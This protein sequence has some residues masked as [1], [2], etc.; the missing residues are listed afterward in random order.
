MSFGVL[1][2]GVV[3]SFEFFCRRALTFFKR[4]LVFMLK[5]VQ[6]RKKRQVDRKSVESFSSR[7]LDGA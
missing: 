4:D 3:K 6:F 7:F 5:D 2:E 1:E